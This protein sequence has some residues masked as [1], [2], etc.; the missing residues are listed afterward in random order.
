MTFFKVTSELYVSNYAPRN[1]YIWP[2]YIGVA[3]AY[4]EGR[5]DAR[6]QDSR[7]GS[8]LFDMYCC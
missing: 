5:Y 8:T 4:R 6:N 7:I 3:R 2:I 1:V